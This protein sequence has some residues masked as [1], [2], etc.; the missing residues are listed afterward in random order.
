MSSRLE[1]SGQ[2]AEHNGSQYINGCLDWIDIYSN[3]STVNSGTWSAV[4]GPWK[5]PITTGNHSIQY[6]NMGLNTGLPGYIRDGA[7]FYIDIFPDPTYEIHPDGNLFGTNGCLG[8]QESGLNC[9]TLYKMI[10]RYTYSNCVLPL[11]VK[12]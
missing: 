7:D 4:S 5:S 1:F 2:Y 11:S 10:R 6:G 8:I 3:G 12:Y 9:L